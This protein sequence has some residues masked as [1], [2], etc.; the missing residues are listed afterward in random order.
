[1]DN[2]VITY[3]ITSVIISIFFA[4]VFLVMVYNIGKIKGN[5]REITYHLTDRK[6]ID[7]LREIISHLTDQKY[8]VYLTNTDEWV[9]YRWDQISVNV[10]YI[11]CLMFGDGFEVR[12]K[13]RDALDFNE[14]F[15]VMKR[16][17]SIEEA[18]TYYLSVVPGKKHPK[19]K[20]Q[21]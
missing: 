5:L 12:K 20:F 19:G 8:I 9:E 13:T 18:K 1:M 3:V 11:K 7:H 6:Y 16:V 2:F 15:D 4:I 14:K 17:G 10:A 21:L